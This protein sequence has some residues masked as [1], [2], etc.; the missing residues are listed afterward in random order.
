MKPSEKDLAVRADA[1]RKELQVG[2]GNQRATEEQAV[3]RVLECHQLEIGYQVGDLR[4]W[5]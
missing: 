5:Q 2:H 3:A 4:P 1:Q